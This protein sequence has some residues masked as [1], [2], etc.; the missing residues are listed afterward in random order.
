[1]M[2]AK[3]GGRNLFLIL[4]CGFCFFLFSCGLESIVYLKEP[5]SD[6]EATIGDDYLGAY[7]SFITNDGY[8][9]SI[10][11]INDFVYL[12]TDV[13]YKIF[14]DSTKLYKECAE[15]NGK[16]DSSTSTNAASFLINKGFK[17]LKFDVV[18]PGLCSMEGRILGGSSDKYVYIRP[19]DLIGNIGIN[20]EY[21]RD[22]RIHSTE[23]KNSTQGTQIGLPMRN[24]SQENSF[25][26]GATGSGSF[27]CK[28]SDL[29]VESDG[30]VEGSATESG[31]WYVAAYAV[32]VGRD[33][34]WQLSYSNV[35]Y[36]GA[37][38]INAAD[39]INK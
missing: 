24:T 37:I 39:Y 25:D 4:T 32:S 6:H 9:S 33:N 16:K 15:I 7:F 20:S 28:K 18:S 21:Q 34:N 35:C 38:K 14:G 30:D 23:I 12:G 5:S 26:F 2:K 31:I 29:P 1:M 27:G 3:S 10:N 8:N 13:Y 22:V 17:T 11:G 19:N 36:L